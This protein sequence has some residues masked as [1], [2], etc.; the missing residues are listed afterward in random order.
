[1][2]CVG[3]LKANISTMVG[4]LYKKGD[5]R[6]DKGFTIFYMGINF[7]SALSSLLVGYIGQ[8]YGWHYGF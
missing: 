5:V 4:Q 3:A 2:L 1:M 8:V 7:G 6:R